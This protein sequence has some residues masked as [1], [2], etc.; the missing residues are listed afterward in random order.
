MLIMI[1]IITVLQ[2]GSVVMEMVTIAMLI[3]LQEHVDG[4]MLQGGA[5]CGHVADIDY[6]LASEFYFILLTRH[7]ISYWK[8]SCSSIFFCMLKGAPPPL[9]HA[10][11]DRT[12]CG[13]VADIDYILASQLLSTSYLLK[14]F[15]MKRF[16]TTFNTN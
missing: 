14:Y 4:C 16:L 9:E 12:S 3:T 11:E 2:V 10:K 5:L 1:L 15:Y 6:I 13:H 7:Y 8:F